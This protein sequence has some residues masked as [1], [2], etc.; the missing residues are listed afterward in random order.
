[1]NNDIKIGVSLYS[2]ST[3]FIHEELD[4]EGC[5]K[6]VRDMGYKG[7][8]IVAAQMVP[9]YPFPS[10][11]WLYSFRGMLEKYEL[12]PVCWSAYIDMGIRSDRDLTEAEIIQ[13]TVND[14][15]YA[16]KA[17]FPMVRTQ[18]A[19]SPRIFRKMI[20]LC[21]DLDMKLTIEMHWPHHPDVPVWQ[22]YFKIMKGEGK[23]YLGF[24]PDFSIFQYMPHQLYLRQAQEFGCRKEALDRLVK[25]HEMSNEYMDSHREHELLKDDT[26]SRERVR[27]CMEHVEKGDFT[28]IEKHYAEEMFGKFNHPAKIEQFKDVMDCVFYVHG[29]FYYLDNDVHDPCIDYEELI[30]KFIEYGYK[31]Y[32]A[33][34]FEGHHFYSDVDC[35]DQLKHYVAMNNNILEKL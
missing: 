6:A 21:K 28:D 26:E 19:I 18:H 20:P 4:L 23:G 25:I 34:E 2:L 32:I 15:I 31:G 22:E 5:L 10:D 11:E 1:M 29:K 17:G 33:S 35:V 12:E 13:Y 27:I 9:E 14:L 30:P 7:V 16:K 3:P 24:V 8:E